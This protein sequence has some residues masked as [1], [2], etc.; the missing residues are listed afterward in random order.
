MWYIR[1]IYAVVFVLAVFVGLRFWSIQSAYNHAAD[2]LPG[3]SVG[4]ADA[5]VTVVEFLD[6]R[7]AACRTAH[8]S[9]QQIISEFPDVR[10]TYRHMPVF[11]NQSVIE[12]Q[13]ALTAAR[14]GKF[15]EAHEWLIGRED[16]VSEDEIAA[17]ATDIGQDPAVFRQEMK[18]PENAEIFF[19]TLDIQDA[20]GITQTPAFLIN[21]KLFMPTIGPLT[22]DD[23]RREIN[24]ARGTP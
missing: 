6:Y 17:F 14:H 9:V 5:D 3:M 8:A 24:A 21:R 10:F 7:C 20:L 13:I 12:G 22:T 19:K 2:T 4:P 11:G 16:P 15:A 1:A 23:L 18:Q